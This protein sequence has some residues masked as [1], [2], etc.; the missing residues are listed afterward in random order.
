VA[1]TARWDAARAARIRLLEVRGALPDE[2]TDPE[3][4]V[5]FAPEKGTV[6]KK[7]QYACAACGAVQDV[8]TT[9]KASGKTGPIAAY[10]VQ[11]Y[12]PNRSRAGK[13]YGGR[14]F[15][16]ADHRSLV[17]ADVEWQEIL[18]YVREKL[19]RYLEQGVAISNMKLFPDGFA[20]SLPWR[21]NT[22]LSSLQ[23]SATD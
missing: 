8:L 6:P 14:F 4:G 9:I 7:S 1:A 5:T 21:P 18:D 11:A 12:S 17:A 23:I 3:T 2:V 10:A 19:E 22:T 16:V 13:P 20:R 15:A